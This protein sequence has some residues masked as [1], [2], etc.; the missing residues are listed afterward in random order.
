MGQETSER[1][2]A[3]Q[4]AGDRVKA[5]AEEFNEAVDVGR[6]HQFVR[7][8]I[9]LH[10]GKLVLH[11]TGQGKYFQ[12]PPQSLEARAKL[13]Q[14]VAD[15]IDGVAPGGELSHLDLR[16]AQA[17]AALAAIEKEK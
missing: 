4:K 16:L 17:R 1:R 6:A 11:R 9:V 13:V 7:Q 8:S 10:N 2:T 5:A 15:A 12:K 14:A 3:G